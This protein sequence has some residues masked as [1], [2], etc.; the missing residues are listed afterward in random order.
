LTLPAFMPGLE[1]SRVFYDEAVAPILERRFAG[2]RYAAGRLD[3]G[4]EVLGFDTARSMDHWWGPRV[5]LFVRTEDDTVELR[6]E[7]KRVLGAELPFAVRDFP[8]HMHEVD[9]STGS[10]FMQHTERRPINHMVFVTTVA[11]FGREYLGLQA[12][13]REPA[14][15]EWL[16]MPEQHLRTVASGG[17]WHDDTGEVTRLRD[18]L[19]WYPD[20]VWR[21]LLAAQW[22]RIA[23][24]EPFPGRCVEACDELGSRVVTARLVREVMHLAFLLER[25]YMAYAKWLGTAF[26]R[27]ACAPSLEPH[28]L[29][30]LGATTWP[31]RE[32]SMS[33]AYELVAR[34]QNDT[35]L[36]A[37]VEDKVSPFY[38]RPFLIIHGDSFAGALRQAITD[39]RV[40]RLPPN[41]GNT[42]Q[43]VDS[44]DLLA[45][46]WFERLRGLYASR[47]PPTSTTFP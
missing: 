36:A 8:T 23:Q 19:R 21:Y 12:V 15:D 44:T 28:L 29:A 43:W 11:E 10:V 33:A 27:L 26:S 18:W 6:A 30:A 39:E 25:Q 32:R 14:V 3:S 31:E 37:D 46:R 42:T 7:I 16:V 20:D 38:G 17:I 2:L 40:K 4:S 1:L 24:E 45:P 22:R 47:V 35:G 5:Q 34:M 9:V 41:P 13:D